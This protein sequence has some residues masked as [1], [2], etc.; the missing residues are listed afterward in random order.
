MNAGVLKGRFKTA[1]LDENLESLQT[2]ALSA[3]GRIAGCIDVQLFVNRQSGDFIALGLYESAEA[4]DAA[5][6]I[7]EEI[8]GEVAAQLEGPRPERES[9]DLAVSAALGA[10]A[11][12]ERSVD[13]INRGDLEQFARDLAPDARWIASAGERRGPQAVKE[14]VQNWRRAFPDVR[15]TA[16]HV[17]AT[18]T[19]V[20][21]EAEETGTHAGTWASRI[22]ELPATGRSIRCE[23]ALVYTVDRGLIS[24]IH[25]Y[26]D[27]LTL[28]AQLGLSPAQT[29]TST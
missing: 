13:A 17:M 19:S 16:T 25:L 15:L 10:R 3:L 18:G 22:G 9:Y 29:A 1:N 23:V 26:G 7:G 14:G 28:T 2:R 27:Y 8:L 20:L 11:L 5:A 21:V 12:V 4:R 24:S 6:S